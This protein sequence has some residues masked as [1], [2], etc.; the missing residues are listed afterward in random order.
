MCGVRYKG[1]RAG[2]GGGEVGN[3]VGDNVE[4]IP[5]SE[6]ERGKHHPKQEFGQTL[7]ASELLPQNLLLLKKGTNLAMRAQVS[8]R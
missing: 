2:I 8:V 7:L 3:K 5:L 6:N 4:I 1:I